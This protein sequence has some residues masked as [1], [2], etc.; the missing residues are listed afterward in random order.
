MCNARDRTRAQKGAGRTASRRLGPTVALLENRTLLSTATATTLGISAGSL[1][2]GQS[3]VLTATVT[4]SPPSATTPSGGTVSFMDGSTTLATEGLT[5]GTAAFTTTS[6]GVGSHSLMAVYSGDAA[7]GSSSSVTAASDITTIAGGGNGNGGPATATSL[8]SPAAVALDAAGDIFIADSTDD[9]IREVNTHGVISTVAGNGTAGYSGDG[10]QATAA[11]LNTPTGIAL[12]AAGDIFIADSSNNVIR[13]VNGS[14]GVIT[15]FAGNGTAGYS[16]DHGQATAAELKKPS[17]VAIDSAGDV[18]IADTANNVIRE[19]N[20]STR[21]IT[22]IAGDGTAGYSGDHGQATAADLSGPTG[23]AVSSTGNI[24]IADTINNVVREVSGGVI[25]TVAGD[26]VAGYSG[27]NGAA[28]TA[29]LSG[30]TGIAIDSSGN[31][32]IAD[33]GNNVIRRVAGGVIT[34]VVGDGTAGYSGDGGQAI[35][36]ELAVPG[37]LAVNSAGDIFVADTLNAVIREVSGGVINTVAGN[38]FA[39]YSGDGGQ[40]TAAEL[41][42]PAGVV[43]NAAGDIFIADS[44]NSVIRE[45]NPAT[46]VITTFAGN[47]FAGYSGDGGH[48]TSAEL[49][50]AQAMAFDSAGDLFIADSDNCVIREVNA[51]T[52]DITT[53]AGNGNIGYSGDNGPATAAELYD[54]LGV[55]V[56]AAGDIFIADSLNNVI[57]EVNT[58]GVITTVAGNGTAGY[59]GDNGPATAAE[60]NFPTGIAIDSAGDIYFA[61]SNNNVIREVSGGVITT[62][63]GNGT[64]GYSGDRGPATAAELNFPTGVAFDSSG[65]LYIDD[66]GNNVIREVSAGVITTVAGNGTGGYSGDGGPATTAEIERPHRHRRRLLRKPLH[67]R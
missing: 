20:G 22:T 35:A 62:V 5:N 36:A 1:V 53:V 31:L 4:T 26:G 23:I 17:A 34:T 37:G 45:I 15:T 3:E 55:A 12:D 8:F 56:N 10:G 14:T 61:D 64:A 59:S 65:D 42:Q 21:V 49:Y 25:T 63:A 50:F 38:G 67:R 43:V 46:G 44:L 47:G 16:G 2:Y 29:A 24:F 57:R 52:G 6:L 9:V 28:T 27:D 7:F 32:D 66:S 40:A 60:L 54:P 51:S 33:T 48:A 11:E 18:Y 19:V 41:D 58:L 30:P 39:S 13:E